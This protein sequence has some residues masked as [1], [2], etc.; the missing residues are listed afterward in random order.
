MK[1]PGFITAGAILTILIILFAIW[2]FVHGGIVEGLR[3]Q[4]AV[5]S[6]TPRTQGP[7]TLID[8]ERMR[9]D[10]HIHL[11]TSP[12]NQAPKRKVLQAQP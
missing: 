2:L 8:V 5:D 3:L 4:P 6:S 1:K 11:A 9:Y 12:V 10:G 7:F